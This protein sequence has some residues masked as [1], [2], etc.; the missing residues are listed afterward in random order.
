MARGQHERVIENF[1]LEISRTAA[2]EKL[3]ILAFRNRR[4]YG[5]HIEFYIYTYLFNKSPRSY[6]KN[7]CTIVF[8]YFYAQLCIPLCLA[9]AIT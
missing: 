5:V 4:M 1:L 9:C 6:N 3:P 2:R 7:H 8:P